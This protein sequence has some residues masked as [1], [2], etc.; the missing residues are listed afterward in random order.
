MLDLRTARSLTKWSLLSCLT[1]LPVAPQLA[2]AQPGGIVVFG[3]SLSD[4][5][6]AYAALGA[7]TTPPDW[8]V[9]AFLVPDRPY[10]RGGHHF[11]N[12]ATWIE[13]F[14]RPLGL[15]A[16]TKGAFTPG[17]GTNFAFGGARARNFGTSP[18][19]AVQVGL[20]LQATGGTAPAQALYVIEMGGNDMRDAMQALFE[21]QPAEATQILD[22]AFE[23]IIGSIQTLHAAGAR[24]FLL[25]NMPNIGTTPALSPT[26][27]AGFADFFAQQFNA[28]L[29]AALST[30][31]GGID[32][33]V[34]DVYGKVGAVVAQPGDFGLTNATQACI[35]VEAPFSCAQ[36]NDHL[37]W[38]GIHPTMAGHAIFAHEA[39]AALAH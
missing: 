10:A 11:S 22:A 36:P 35:S 31:L 13:Q 4:P 7:A 5:G 2:T 37:F 17:G 1:L 6:N 3:T 34:L 8:S 20:F 33:A 9:D 16:S 27:L 24:R 23:A 21:G 15:A 14:A 39:A 32:I 28:N 30:T 12:G 18:S 19:L 25:W 26:P 29:A 38:D